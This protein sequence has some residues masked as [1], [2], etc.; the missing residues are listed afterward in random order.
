AKVNG[1]M[2]Q[3][4]HRLRSGDT[5]E[6]LTSKTQ[7]PSKDWLKIVKTSRA[8]AKIKQYLLKVEREN[9]RKIGMEILE[10]ALKEH[11]TN[12]KTLEHRNDFAAAYDAMHINNL[13]ELFKGLSSAKI[14]LIAF[15]QLIPSIELKK[16]E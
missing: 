15:L 4:K 10:K 14:L 9:N 13:E 5:V 2:V 1:K 3:L 12:E 6:V 7:T 11:G 8:R 16:D